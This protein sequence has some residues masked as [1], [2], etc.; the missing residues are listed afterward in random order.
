VRDR[1]VGATAVRGHDSHE[2]VHLIGGQD[3]TNSNTTRRILLLLESVAL[4]QG[5]AHKRVITGT[6]SRYLLEERTFARD[7]KPLH[8]PRFLLNDFARYW[9]TM[10][11]DFAYKSRTRLGE[12]SA[13]R[14]LK[15]RMSRKLIFVSGLLSCF[16]C[17]LGMARVGGHADC[18]AEEGECVVCL[19]AFMRRTPLEIFAQ[20]ALYLAEKNP[21]K[22][23]QI[24]AFAEKAVTAYDKFLSILADEGKR[25]D[26]EKLAQADID[27]DPLFAEA[28]AISHEFRDGIDGFFFDGDADLAKLTRHYGVF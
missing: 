24:L 27:S 11:V 6:L 19:R 3:D 18:P 22:A 20:T 1:R 21:A 17:Q 13:L 2:L 14:N 10:A 7:S 23:A 4:G 5:A 12:G 28:R 15:L 8:V 16:S 9:R 26:L 25:E